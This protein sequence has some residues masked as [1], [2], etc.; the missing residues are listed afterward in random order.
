MW[1][2]SFWD[3]GLWISV[4]SIIL[5][6]TVEMTSPYNGHTNLLINWK[7]LRTVALITTIIFLFTVAVRVY[8]ILAA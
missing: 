6:I 1:P 8:E 5:L 3:I 4:T 2:L 7:R